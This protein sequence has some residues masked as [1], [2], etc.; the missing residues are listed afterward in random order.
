[1][2][3]R[4]GLRIT[5]P[6]CLATIVCLLIAPQ[7]PA[8]QIKKSAPV[9]EAMKLELNRSVEQFKKLPTPPYFL[10]YEIVENEALSAAA[11][12]G[13]LV[14]SNS[15]SRRRALSIDLRVGSFQLDNTHPIRGTGL[16]LPDMVSFYPMLVD[17]APDALR[18]L[19]WY[20]TD[21]K[22]KRAIEQLISVKTN[23][24]VKVD[25]TDRAGDF[26]AT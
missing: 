16:N 21:Q 18:A 5:A 12:F 7:R 14:S 26:S 24:K 3:K 11:S 2:W 17:D 25:E 1:M 15:G 8:A 9:F 10:S 20:F 6:A 4:P 22:Y 13:A 19:L 23:V